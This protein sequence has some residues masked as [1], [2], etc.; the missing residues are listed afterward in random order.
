[1]E[2]PDGLSVSVP[3]L[4]RVCASVRFS[5]RC[6]HCCPQL[7]AREPTFL[8]GGQQMFCGNSDVNCCVTYRLGQGE[9]EF[10]LKG[11]E[12]FLFSHPEW[13]TR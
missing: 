11:Q 4:A 5:L 9:K 6:S 2:F 8:P 12:G 13:Q 3:Q 10:G 7:Y 1:M